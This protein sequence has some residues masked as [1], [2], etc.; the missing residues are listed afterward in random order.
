M[1]KTILTK[2]YLF[3]SYPF[4]YHGRVNTNYCKNNNFNHIKGK[5]NHMGECG[6]LQNFLLEVEILVF[7]NIQAISALVCLQL[8][9]IGS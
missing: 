2:N 3:N 1:Y 7:S 8:D 4:I 5:F 9:D 6:N